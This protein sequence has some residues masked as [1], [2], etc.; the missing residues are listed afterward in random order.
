MYEQIKNI[1]IDTNYTNILEN[2]WFPNINFPNNNAN[3]TNN[4]E[5]KKWFFDS[6]IENLIPK[7]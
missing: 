1:V 2:G 7:K 6:F 3:S 4:W 5:K